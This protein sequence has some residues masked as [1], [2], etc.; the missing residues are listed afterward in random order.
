MKPRQL[1]PRQA[2]WVELLSPFRFDIIYRPGKQAS[3]PDAL[4]CRSDYHPCKGTTLDQEHNFVQ[5]LPRFFTR[6]AES[7][8]SLNISNEP[9]NSSNHSAKPLLVSIL[10]QIRRF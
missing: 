6:S 7:L 9:S 10:P 8:E 4:S 2:R 1:S 3:M 5:A